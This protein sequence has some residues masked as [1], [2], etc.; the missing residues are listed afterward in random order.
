MT[1]VVGG[2]MAI[3][4]LSLSKVLYCDTHYHLYV[5]TVT[6]HWSFY[7]NLLDHNV[8]HGHTLSDGL[9]YI[10]LKYYFLS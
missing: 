3:S 8:Y 5:V 10:S 6:S 4:S 9:T 1:L 7:S 2:D